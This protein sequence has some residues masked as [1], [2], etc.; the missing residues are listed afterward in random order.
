[1]YM[2]AAKG[3]AA[4]LALLVDRDR[5]AVGVVESHGIGWGRPELSS[6]CA[7]GFCARI[8]PARMRTRRAEGQGKAR[9]MGGGG[10]S[11]P[12]GRRL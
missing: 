10:Q 5:A 9:E 2:A 3:S 8:G 6:S 1:M 4:M 7:S 11:M 12:T